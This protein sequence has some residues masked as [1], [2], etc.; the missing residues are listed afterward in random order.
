MIKCRICDEGE[1]KKKKKFRLSGIVVF[2]GYIIL[3]P[4]I[5]GI[6]IGGF[7]LVAT[8]S[9]S[10]EVFESLKDDARGEMQ[11]AGVP[12]NLIES[13]LEGQGPSDAQRSSLSVEQV[14]AI[15]SAQLTL[16]AGT[17]GA[18][19]GVALAG[20]ASLFVIISSLVGG[21]V[22]WLLTMKKKVLQCN[23]CGSVTA[24]S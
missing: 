2:V 3:I 15:D 22:G 20:G 8:G 21:I 16:S 7:G 6:L 5:I 10:G 1:L 4:S 14:R 12:Q 24:A 13:V 11:A 17:A 23:K 9:S 18:G 19:I